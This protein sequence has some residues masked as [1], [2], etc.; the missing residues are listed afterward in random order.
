MLLWIADAT[1][2]VSC[3]RFQFIYTLLRNLNG[4]GQ[5]QKQLQFCY[6]Q[7]KNNT[8]A[9]FFDF[10]GFKMVFTIGKS[11]ESKSHFKTYKSNENTTDL[12][13]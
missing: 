5:S 12:T 4:I 3:N 10:V 1:D 9:G 8:L 13:S 11:T 6:W 2:L 7:M